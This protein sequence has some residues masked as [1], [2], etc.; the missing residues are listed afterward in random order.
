MALAHRLLAVREVALD[1]EAD[2]LHHYPE[3]LCLVQIAAGDDAYLIDPLPALDL[4]PLGAV[5]GDSSI[6]TVVHAGDNDLAVL[7]RRFG[8]TF[9]HLFDTSIAA[10]FLGVREL[11]LDV[12]LQRFLGVAPERSR[13][14]DDWSVRP[15]TAEQE[16]YAVGDVK[17]LVALKD[18][19][20]GELGARGRETWVLEECAALA[21]L[22]VPERPVDPEAYLKLRGAR[23][24]PSR[25][26]AIL[27][28]LFALR[29]RLALSRDRPP[30]K[31]FADETL[32][33]LAAR[34]PRDTTALLAVPGCT[35]GVVE[36]FGAAILA[37]VEEGET[38]PESDLP[39]P[40]RR[41]APP[42]VPAPVRR[43]TEA[44]KAWRAA[45]AT[46]LDLDPGVLLPGR[47]IDLIA[48]VPHLD[49]EALA[50]LD[51][52]RSWRVREFG[53][54]LITTVVPHAG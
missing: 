43:R 47:L 24:L 12:M 18:L 39:I 46:R 8:F 27:R 38:L 20:L 52:L 6:L 15:L 4:V 45:A 54:E 19:L 35:S 10:R 11:G 2:S 42:A 36:R 50:R 16:A 40:S 5:F 26:L 1:T 51:G 3:R 34:R 23:A 17:H 44:L 9:A 21:A 30:F 28:A 49:L 31:I 33:E 13:Q 53:A 14:K 22:V 25:S 32:R 41:P 37:A 29:L 48:A 7:K